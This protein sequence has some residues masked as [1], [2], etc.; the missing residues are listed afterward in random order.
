MIRHE[1]IVYLTLT[2]AILMAAYTFYKITIAIV[3]LIQVKRTSNILMWE[4]RAIN[5]VDALFSV[6]IL[7]S[8]LTR[9]A[10]RGKDMTFLTACTSGIIWSAIAFISL[11]NTYLGIKLIIS[12]KALHEQK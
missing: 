1:N 7:Q 4:A 8:V 2:P 12:R 9:V 11:Y 5:T 3:R 10:D 6:I